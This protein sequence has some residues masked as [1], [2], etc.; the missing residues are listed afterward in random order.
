M[1][2]AVESKQVAQQ[3]AER[4][5]F[6]VMKAEQVRCGHAAVTCRVG[7]ARMLAAATAACRGVIPYYSAPS[8]V[9]AASCMPAATPLQPASFAA[10]VLAH[11]MHRRS[12][13]RQ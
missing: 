6:I 2:Q 5:R 1:L 4:A 13:R 8:C 12:A 9:P 7:A 3:E 10:A 11:L